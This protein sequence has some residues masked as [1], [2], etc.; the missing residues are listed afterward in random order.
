MRRRSS[1]PRA[2]C[3]RLRARRKLGTAIAA[4][5]AIIAT[6]IM[7]STRVKPPR[8]VWNFSNIGYLDYFS[9]LYNYPWMS[10]WVDAPLL[11]TA[12]ATPI[13]TAHAL[14]MEVRTL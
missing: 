1:T 11:S 9:Y 10:H 3:E 4:N 2:A 13:C 14:G 5:S 12:N 7:I 6:T 8:L